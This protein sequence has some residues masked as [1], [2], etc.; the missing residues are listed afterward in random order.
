AAA[1]TAGITTSAVDRPARFHQRLME[2]EST[3]TGPRP[4]ST[5][6]WTFPALGADAGGAAGLLPSPHDRHLPTPR[7]AGRG[8]AGPG[9]PRPR[10]TQRP[11]PDA[12]R[13]RAVRLR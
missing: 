8:R 6:G 7:R 2:R 5:S 10:P 1:S 3:P 4:E 9:Q 12:H 11:R 13:E